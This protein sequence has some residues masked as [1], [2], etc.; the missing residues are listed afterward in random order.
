MNKDDKIKTFRL[1]F[2]DS[3]RFMNSSLAKLVNNLS[4]IKETNKETDKFINIMRSSATTL[5][6]S[7]NN[8]SK[9]D[10]KETSEFT[11]NMRSRTTS[12]LACIDRYEDINKKIMIIDLKERFPS[13]HQL[14][15]N[16]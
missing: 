12:L 10:K 11:D 16:D 4:D 8:Y 7:I 6:K 2:V 15:D 3:Q 1:K 5:Q 13:T 9:L 14:C